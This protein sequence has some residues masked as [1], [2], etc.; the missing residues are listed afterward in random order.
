MSSYKEGQVHMLV[1][2]LEREGWTGD[3]LTKFGQFKDKKSLRAVILGHAKIEMVKHLIDCSADPYLPNNWKVVEHRRTGQ[4]EWDPTKIFPYLSDQQK[5]GGVIRGLKLREELK[6]KPVLNA[7]VLDYLLAHPELIPEDWK[8]KAVFFWGT[9]YR[10]SDGRLCVRYL[11]WDDGRWNRRYH[12]LD[13]GWNA[14]S[15]AALSLA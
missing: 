11:I 10:D 13:N 3:D 12:W 6:G 9:I 5:E 2:E 15:P 7:N 14:S 8:D 4:L 1:E